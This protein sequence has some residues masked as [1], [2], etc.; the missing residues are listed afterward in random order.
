MVPGA[1]HPGGVIRLEDGRRL[2]YV[3]WGKGD[4]EPVFHFHGSP[5]GRLERWG[6]DS[7]LARHGV[8]LITTDRPGIGFSDR[9][10]GRRVIDWPDDIRQLADHLGLDR[11]G[12]IGFSAGAAYAAACASRLADRLVG[13]ALVSSV[14]RIDERGVDGMGTARYLNL[15]RRAPWAMRLIYTALAWQARRNPAR[16]HEQFWRGVSSVDR[17][18]VDRPAVRA[19]YWPAL[20]DAARGRGRGLVD[21]MRTLQRPWGFDP[22]QI[23]I[24]IHLF[25]GTADRMTPPSHAEYWIEILADCDIRSYEDEGH[26]LIEDHMEE[27]LGTVVR[28]ALG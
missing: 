24:P 19:R 14:G 11:F 13:A 22:A 9:Q 23:A 7:V 20:T 2:G 3:E 28:S 6:E 1:P 5:A 8:R 4:A 27:I 26:F 21:E 16:A 10:R 18:V 12:V 25:H 17:A 15:A